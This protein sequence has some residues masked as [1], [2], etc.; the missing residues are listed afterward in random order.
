MID[1]AKSN[2]KGDGFYF[3]MWGWL[4]FIAALLNFILMKFTTFERPYLAWTLLL[5][6]AV[7]SVIKGIKAENKVK[8]KTYLSETMNYFGISLGI[9]YG[10][11]AFVFGYYNL[12]E[13]S[14]PIYILLYGVGCF[15]MGS[16]LQFN[17]LKWGGLLCIPVMV[18]S[19]F[20][21]YQWQ[22]LFMAF[23]VLVSY[24]IP[25]HILNAKPK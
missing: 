9:L 20:V 23:A 25:G 18:A 15:F 17:F 14:F 6:G 11:L 7:I 4:V 21:S 24:I 8:V 1:K 3:L 22:L 2:V 13:Q 5:I 12:W 10:G 16:L 19:L